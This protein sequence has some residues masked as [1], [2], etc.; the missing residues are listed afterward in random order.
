ME[1]F[2]IGAFTLNPNLTWETIDTPIAKLTIIEDFYE[3]FDAV[4]NEM[5]KLPG[6]PT[7]CNT[8]GE[9][10]DYRKCYGANMGGT[11]APYFNQYS[12]I[13]DQIIEWGGEIH[14]Q[15]QILVNVNLLLCNK[16][17]DY[18]YNIHQDPVEGGYW[19]DRISTVVMLN[20]HYDEGEGTN[21]YYHDTPAH[22]MWS[23]KNLVPRAHFVQGKANRAILFSPYMWH[24]AAL[25]TDQFKS[26]YRYTQAI[27]SDLR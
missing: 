22:G 14:T 9:I 15:P 20:K 25:T 7:V 21:F 1:V 12:K 6:V 19:K 16:N 4:Y 10:E 3:D 18:W 8:P 5:L 27:F 17:E 11:N 24:S 23:A 13:V 2:N 26:E